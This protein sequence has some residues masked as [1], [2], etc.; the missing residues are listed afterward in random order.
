MAQTATW[1]LLSIVL[2]SVA[3]KK[4]RYDLT[5]F[6]CLLSLG[7]LGIRRPAI[8]FSGFSTPSLYTIILVLVMSGGIVESG[9][10]HGFGKAIARR[11]NK[12]GEQIL[13]I[14]FSTTLLS[15]F[16]NN[17]GAVGILL[18]TAKR[19]ASRANVPESR[20]GFAIV[21]ASIL[22]GSL[23]L[24]GTASNLIVSTARFNAYGK[25]FSMFDFTP[26]GIVMVLCGAAA[27]MLNRYSTDATVSSGTIEGNDS[28]SNDQTN[29]SHSRRSKIIVMASL[30][31][32]IVVIASGWIHPAIGFGILVI[33]WIVTG[34]FSY[35]SALSNINGPLFIFLGSMFGISAALEETGAL[36]AIMNIVKPAFAVLPHFLI[37][38][39]FVFVTALLANILDNSVAAV[40]MSPIAVG[41]QSLGIV[42]INPDAL[43]MAVAAGASLGIV[44]PTHQATIVVMHRLEFQNNR[45][46]AMGSIITLAAG[47][48]ASLIIFV[49]WK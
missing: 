33:L 8:L 5:A 29:P 3:T 7:I 41:L 6:F 27:L 40:L 48:A 1:I 19:M 9:L 10:L 37:V 21:Y 38:I 44:L 22:G 42:G 13:S 36:M 32:T 34:V 12:P 39:L 11:F 49:I 2:W 30:I 47:L 17:I 16:M 25:P 43:L 14:F 20:F 15:A 18:P 23:T 45:F 28:I 26:H 31:P 46:T 35:Q 4:L 24:I